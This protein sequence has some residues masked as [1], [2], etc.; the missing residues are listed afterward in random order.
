VSLVEGRFGKA[1]DAAASPVTVPGSDAFR[2]PPLT[3]ECWA[4]LR[5]R[6]AFNVLVAADPK[7]STRH[8]EVYT[9]AR[10]GAFAAYLPGYQP[11]EVVSGTNAADGLWHYL[12]MTFDGKVVRLYVDG[13]SV[14]E[15]A[16]KPAAGL[17]P[18]PGPLTIGEAVEGSGGRIGCDGVIDEVRISRGVRTITGVPREELTHDPAT[19]GLWHFNEAEGLKADPAW[20]PPPVEAGAAWQ[21]QTDA[22]WIDV[23]LR[24]MDTG[25]TFNATFRYPSGGAPVLAY[26]GTAVRLGEDGKAAVLFD[27]NRLRW[28]AGWTGGW[29][30]HSDRRF[31]LLNTP[32]PVGPITFT[33]ASGP[34]WADPSG[35]WEGAGAA[36]A[37]LPKAWGH[38][39]G[40]HLHGKRVVLSSRIGGVS[41]KESPWVEKEG[42]LTV[43][44]RTVEV[45][46]SEKPLTLLACEFPSPGSVVVVGPDLALV[47]A[48]KE[49]TWLLVGTSKGGARVTSRVGGKTRAEVEV[50]PGKETRRFKILMAQ[51]PNDQLAAFA[52][53]VKNSPPPEDLTPLCKAGP[54]R[55]KD[56]VTHG[57][58]GTE[59]GPYAV[60]TLTVPYSNPYKAL[61]FLSGL[62]FLPDGT[63]A[64]C[65]AH[66]DVWLVKG[67][68]DGLEKLTWK[69]F[70]TGL[71]Q[72]LGLKVV[73]G[74]IVVL[75]RGQLTRLHD[76]DGDGEA[77][78]YENV[79]NDW[80]T[81]PGEHSYDT[82]LETDPAG[83]YY[84]F[85]TGDPHLPNGGCL[86]H[87]SR[88]GTRAEVF[89]TGFRHPI[90]LSV[91]PD[92]VVT[93][94]DQQGNWM[95]ATRIDVYHRGG[96]Y[97]DMRAHHRA[98]APTIY[99]PPLLW[100]PHS[101]DNSAGGQAWVTGDRFGLPAGS[102]L[103]LSYGQCKLFL[104][105][106]QEVEGVAQAGAVDMGLFFLSGAMRGRFNPRDGQ[107]Y[108]CGLRGWQNA[109]RADGCLQRVRSTGKPIDLPASLSVEHDGIRLGFRSPLDREQAR[110]RSRYGIE[111]WGYRWTAEY[112]SKDYSVA[113]PSREGHDRLTI[114]RV[115]VAE[116]GKSVFLAVKGLRPVMQ[117][118][119]RYDLATE[120]RPLQGTVYNT[121]NRIGGGR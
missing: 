36:T 55:W 11:A 120:G 16:V 39:E 52:R 96:F 29:L 26:K 92:G 109:A 104:V 44:T 67:V 100:L 13:K 24:S 46:P 81:G 51:V 117:M 42:G 98:T 47:G 38:F 65:S 56:V 5:S 88:D 35:S 87:I 121:I 41:V 14:K 64:V 97:G 69:R 68:N 50:P 75:E 106:R 103:H 94:A 33:T 80:H 9:Y 110:D 59:P 10:T 114:D 70:A 90:G 63:L 53:L 18:V 54:A 77:D 84:F 57:E 2:T 31:G 1:L 71:Y 4:R 111:Q 21:R 45:G 6:H 83:N 12:A 85:K 28:A 105:L 32:S 78:L 15:Q 34:G 37:P 30:E 49:G 23:R 99:D 108:V 7:N 119:I 66:G 112:G 107:L 48:Q 116:D 27:R 19:L 102:L 43:F 20:T 8:W 95:P 72:P 17:K 62:D 3:V 115:T 60:D 74:K 79:C 113:D 76:L 58:R 89:A 61:M 82:C 118:S 91:S 40:M 22:D 101:I 25:P 73:E 86:M 93:G